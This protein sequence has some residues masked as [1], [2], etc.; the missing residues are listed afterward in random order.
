MCKFSHGAALLK[1]SFS[2]RAIDQKAHSNS[3]QAADTQK[4]R[5]TAALVATL[6]EQYQTNPDALVLAWLMRHPANIQ[7]IIGTTNPER[8]R[9]CAEAVKVELSRAHWYQLYVTARGGELPLACFN[10]SKE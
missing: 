9:R 2:G 10:S 6:A 1:G 4:I 5:A 8:I 7:P 3:A